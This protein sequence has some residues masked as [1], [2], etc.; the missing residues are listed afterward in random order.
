MSISYRLDTNKQTHKNY[1]LKVNRTTS[2]YD[3]TKETVKERNTQVIKFPEIN[4]I[5]VISPK[6]LNLVYELELSSAIDPNRS[7]VKNIGR[8]IIDSVDI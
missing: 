7:I 5:S 8:L 2:K 4:S 1:G 6:S 3:I